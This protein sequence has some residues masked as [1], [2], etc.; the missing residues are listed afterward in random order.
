MTVG[1]KCNWMLNSWKIWTSMQS[2]LTC[3]CPLLCSAIQQL[4]R[5]G[6][7][8]WCIDEFKSHQQWQTFFSFFLLECVCF[9]FVCVPFS[10]VCYNDGGERKEIDFSISTFGLFW[11]YIC[12]H[13][14]TEK[15]Y[16]KKRKKSYFVGEKRK[17]RSIM[18][19]FWYLCRSTCVCVCMCLIIYVLVGNNRKILVLLQM[20]LLSPL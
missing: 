14:I 18:R 3:C 7:I 12:A 4:E 8:A 13:N 1:L 6:V 9:V 11:Y 20:L 17:K 5:K 10:C 15:A 2:L 16:S 19:T